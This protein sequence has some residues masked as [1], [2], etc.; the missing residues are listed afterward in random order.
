[1]GK[2]PQERGAARWVTADDQTTDLDALEQTISMEGARVP[3]HDAHGLAPAPIPPASILEGDPV[4]RDKRLAGSTDQLASTYMWDCT[5]G[6]FNWFYD[7]DEVIHVLEGAAI[8]ED[9]AGVRQRLEAGDTFLFPAGSRYRWTVP[10][11]VR[12]IAFLHAPLSR[13][14][15]IIGGVLERLKAPFRRKPHTHEHTRAPL[16]HRHPHYPDIHHQHEHGEAPAGR[17]PN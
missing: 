2:S 7:A 14:M 12:K 4:A 15:R 11:Y 1:M 3:R 17:E 6:S 8:V 5:A 9:S 10:S 16:T 13:E